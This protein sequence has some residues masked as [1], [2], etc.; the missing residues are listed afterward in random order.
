MW[1]SFNFPVLSSWNPSS[2][3][4][5]Q[6]VSVCVDFPR[7]STVANERRHP[8][9]ANSKQPNEAKRNSVSIKT[10]PTASPKCYCG[11]PHAPLH[12]FSKTKKKIIGHNDF[13]SK[14][15]N[16]NIP[17]DYSYEHMIVDCAGLSPSRCAD[18]NITVVDLF[19]K[20]TVITGALRTCM[21]CHVVMYPGPICAGKMRK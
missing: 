20:A 21:S 16:R 4:I 19:E 8:G 9:L 6:N 17:H 13:T 5:G 18:I 14:I 12:L 2:Q 7:S 15:V 3:P 11:V 1:R 10:L